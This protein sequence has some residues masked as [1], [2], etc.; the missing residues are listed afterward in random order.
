MD[1]EM[2]QIIFWSSV[3]LVLGMMASVWTVMTIDPTKD[4]QLYNSD[5]LVQRSSI[6]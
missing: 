5:P 2:F 4:A 6:Y 1:N 3:L